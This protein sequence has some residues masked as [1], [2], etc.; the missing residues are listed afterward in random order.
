V[1][2]RAREQLV[3]RRDTA[4]VEEIDPAMETVVGSLGA[5]R[6]ELDGF[7]IGPKN[8]AGDAAQIVA[9]GFARTQ[10]RGRAAWVVAQK[11]RDVEAFHELR[12]RAKYHWMHLKLLGPLW[13]EVMAP[14][15][16]AAKAIADGLGLD[17]DYAVMRQ[18][19]ARTPDTFGT[20]RELAVLLALVDRRQTELREA[21][22]GTAR[23]LF[24]DD[25]DGVA[26]RIKRLY[27]AAQMARDPGV[28]VAS[29]LDVLRR[30]S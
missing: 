29:P 3:E 17:H 27:R 11:R 30:A 23:R 20:Q 19:I 12:K 10:A 16:T 24:A 15:A 8:K 4:P 28:P 26:T 1:F 13:P 2:R 18:Q 21:A 9:R 22:L 5:A 14:Q 7:V 6:H 25:P